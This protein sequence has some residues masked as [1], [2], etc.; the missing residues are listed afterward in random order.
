MTAP[1]TQRAACAQH[2]D[3]DAWYPAP[4]GDN[5]A[6]AKAICRWCPVVRPCLADALAEETGT[7]A[8]H[9]H[10]I[11]G[12]L[13]GAQRYRLQQRLDRAAEKRGTPL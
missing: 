12:G 13:S 2:P 5:G 10:G 8:D 11:R 1:W 7:S 4:G 9:R 6:A 3:P